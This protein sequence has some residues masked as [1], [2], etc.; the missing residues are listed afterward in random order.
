MHAYAVIGA[1][2]GDEG[3][4]LMTDFLVRK[5]KNPNRCLVVRYNG[6]AQAGHTVVD[7]HTGRR[8][9]FGHIGA[10]T[11]AG[12]NTY[13]ASPFI[14][15]LFA[16]LKEYEQL[17]SLGV[18]PSSFK[19]IINYNCQVTTVF[20]IALNG[21]RELAR[22][23]NPAKRHGSCGMGI[24]ETVTRGTHG[25]AITVSKL[26][27]C[28][29]AELGELLREIYETYWKPQLEEIVAAVK[30]SSITG[31][32]EWLELVA[33]MNITDEA[34]MLTLLKK[35]LFGSKTRLVSAAHGAS[36]HASYDSV[37]FEGA[38][39]L[40]LDEQLGTFPHVTRSITGLPAVTQVASEVRVTNITPVYV[41]RAYAT[42]HGA[43]PLKHECLQGYY[44]FL[45]KSVIEDKTNKF[46]AWQGAFRY[47]RLD[48]Q[49]TLSFIE[50]DLERAKTTEILFRV[51]VNTPRL[52]VTHLDI[53]FNNG[54]VTFKNVYGQDVVWTRDSG[55]MLE[56]MI[57]DE[58]D[59]SRVSNV[60][61][62]CVA[63]E[64]FGEVAETVDT[65]YTRF[66]YLG[67]NV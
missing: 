19:V 37:I 39:G 46:G 1:N 42:R 36:L 32:L 22:S 38:Q 25:K 48:L 41:T 43:G 29:Q 60:M 31:T 56:N 57:S 54:F 14:V 33:L 35:E 26:L 66:D 23:R 50:K 45:D 18:D 4:G 12:A 5:S 2:F 21:L 59:K 51:K 8:H 9:V 40:M 27:E 7:S 24:N 15:N 61:G 16:L 3:K 63:Y 28:D 49:E 64:S 20:D 65:K 34:S 11:F 17:E 67:V 10:G 6:G 58:V 44:D 53:R 62:L 30:D 55:T 13:L 47:A 52:A